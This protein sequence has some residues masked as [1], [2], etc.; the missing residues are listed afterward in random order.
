MKFRKYLTVFIKGILAG[1]CIS[2]GGWLYIQARNS[3]YSLKIIPAFLFSIGLILICHFDFFLYTGKICYLP[4]KIKEKEGLNHIINLLLG[5]IGNY[6]GAL[7]MGLVLS[8]IFNLPD[9]FKTMIDTKLSYNWWQLLILGG[10]C[11]MLIYF[12]VEAFSKIDNCLGKYVVLILC[13]AGFIICGFEHC[14]ADMFY[15]SLAHSFSSHTFVTIILI[16][17]GN[18]LGGVFVPLLKM[19]FNK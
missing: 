16:I 6:L 10:F 4:D 1:I 17:I 13:V 15:F 18:S 11:G 7:V 3:E 12:A 19:I 9:F 14:I 5:L 2:I 8:A